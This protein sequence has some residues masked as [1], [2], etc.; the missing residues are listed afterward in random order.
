MNTDFEQKETKGT[1]KNRT[2]SADFADGRRLGI[3][4]QDAERN[5][6]TANER[7]W[8]RIRNYWWEKVLLPE[9]LAQGRSFYPCTSVF[10]RG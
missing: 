8:T 1:K 2:S 5:E 3:N 4:S 9:R 10:I 6:E 7:E